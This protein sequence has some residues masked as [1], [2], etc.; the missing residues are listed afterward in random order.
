MEFIIS[1]KRGALLLFLIL[2]NGVYAQTGPES[3]APNGEVQYFSVNGG[4]GTSTLLVEG[5]SFNMMADAH[6]LFIPNVAA[7]I[8]A[9]ANFSSDK[10][11]VLE[12]EMY[13]R[14]YF[15]HPVIP[16]DFFRKPVGLFVQGGIGLL[17]AFK[18]SE[19]QDSRSSFLFG[20]A[21]GATIPL[22]S[23]WHVEPSFRVGYPFITG[24]NV[25]A[26]YKF[27]ISHKTE[28]REIPPNEIIRKII[29]SQVE[30]IIFAANISKFNEGLDAS[31]KSLND[32]ILNQIVKTLNEHPEF[33]IRIEGHANPVTTDPKE[34]EE[35]YRL[36]SDRADE[37]SRQLI[38]RGINK[39][40]IVLMA[41]GGTRAV[42]S[43]REDW[44][45]NRRV[46][47]MVIQVSGDNRENS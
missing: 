25:T 8:K 47:L 46:E 22:F 32:L 36:S 42:A 38:S 27:P 33:R 13:A 20:A 17:G 40:Q 9:G 14:W 45:R 18:G 28:Y 16:L 34:A 2:I 15:L 23:N 10:I 7:G 11:N 12:T 3:P 29:I 26:G 31:T 21:V 41:H 6:F 35:L 43:A 24:F 30:Y 1:P 44:S 4:I 37:I 19:V 5:M 39:E